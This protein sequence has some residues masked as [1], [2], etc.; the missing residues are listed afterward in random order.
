MGGYVWRGKKAREMSGVIQ[1]FPFHSLQ[2]KHEPPLDWIW[3]CVV[4]TLCLR[5]TTFRFIYV[6]VSVFSPLA[7]TRLQWNSPSPGSFP[8][9][10]LFRGVGSDP[11]EMA[12]ICP[13]LSTPTQSLCCLTC[14]LHPFLICNL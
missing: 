2:S 1:R 9:A 13:V 11:T 6:C 3:F 5:K 7:K 12:G 14:L 8:E 10:Q 4:A